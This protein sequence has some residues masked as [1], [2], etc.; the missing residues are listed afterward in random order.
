MEIYGRLKKIED[1]YSE[2]YI[3]IENHGVIFNNKTAALVGMDGTID[4]ACLP[5]FDSEPL[6][7]S[8]LDADRGGYFSIRPNR[9]GLMVNQYYEELT[10][11]LVT[12]FYDE[13]GIIVR[14]TDFLPASEY[15]TIN[16][17]EIHRF[18]EPFEDNI[19]I[20]IKI[21][22]SFNYG[23]I[24]PS[25]EHNKNGYIF[26]SL[27]KT[28]GVSSNFNFRQDGDT[29]Y[30]TFQMKRT[31]YNWIVVSTGITHIN[32]ILEY[33]SIERLN[34]T[35][36][37]WKAWS[38]KL[39]YEGIYGKYVLRSALTLKGLFYDP[40][41]MMV[42]APT[43]SLPESIGG[44]RNWDYRF[45]WIRDTAYVIEALSLIGL[46]GEAT[47]F[48]Y[49]IMYK[50]NKQKA[51]KTIYEINDE[52]ILKEKVLDYSGY[53]NS[54]P[55]RIG[56]KASGQF[57]LDQY[58]SI[59]NAIYHFSLA[60]GVITTQLWDFVLG[61]LEKLEVIWKYPDSSIWEFRTEPKHYVYSKLI[62]WS[63]FHRAILMG[64]KLG[65]SAPY[66][67]WRKVEKEIKEDILKN[68]YNN[69]MECFVQSYGSKN[70][71]ASL[72]RLPLM[73]FLNIKDKRVIN[74]IRCIESN[75][76]TPNYLFLRYNKDDGL[77][78]MDNPFLLLSFWYVEDLI[79]MGRTEHA[80]K[81]LETLL[82]KS[83]HLYLFSE[84]INPKT[85][86]LLGNFPQAIT[87]L[88]VIRAIARL[89]SALKD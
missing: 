80:K 15:A 36:K 14:I 18:I 74:T 44:D 24:K 87:H 37:Y 57:Q 88:G 85:G 48:I 56:N 42:A 70:I 33:K 60:D 20:T 5:N 68:G 43:T 65:Y 50:I 64:K 34:E 49:D 86:S 55:V 58:G 51:I 54:R 41:G 69:E 47:K 84:E 13:N 45:T 73:D 8:I 16:M 38:N 25:V 76:M 75:L 77:K 81:V 61:I 31:G 66:E 35:R 4:W 62:S 23:K 32:N 67:T 12:E 22:P 72:L 27:N 1:V 6:F 7:D 11:I 39:N 78:S 10:N 40:T 46:N 82:S 59:I 52:S 3:K 19:K 53:R 83:N 63:A 71:D 28:V 79:L 26:R 89:N 17:P 29:I 21:K 30:G 9:S 2:N